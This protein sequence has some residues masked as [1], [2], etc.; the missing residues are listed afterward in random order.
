WKNGS[1]TADSGLLWGELTEPVPVTVLL[2][3][4]RFAQPKASAGS[5]GTQALT[6][7]GV[8]MFVG[9]MIGLIYYWQFFD[10][11][12]SVPIERFFGQTFGGGRVHNIGLMQ[13]RQSG[14]IISGIA[15]A[16]GFICVLL[17]QYVGKRR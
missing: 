8:I 11:S 2:N 1:I 5:G 6:F 9:G 16:L 14:M 4:P 17:G 15:A 3:Q 10:T 7:L 12:V 13:E